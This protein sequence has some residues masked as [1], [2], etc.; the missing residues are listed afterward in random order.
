[1]PKRIEVGDLVLK[2]GDY[3]GLD[4]DYGLVTDILK[5]KYTGTR[6]LQVYIGFMK[7][8]PRR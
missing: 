6:Y 4:M 8:I 7:S 3:Y 1:M 5:D 2:T